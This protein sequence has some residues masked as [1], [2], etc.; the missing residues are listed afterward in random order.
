VGGAG[1][2]AR[3]CGSFAATSSTMLGKP[4]SVHSPWNRRLL[5]AFS[6][7]IKVMT[8]TLPNP[9]AKPNFFSAADFI[10]SKTILRKEK[11]LAS[12]PP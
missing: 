8:K 6:L 12:K 10:S 4:P 5:S 7:P 11:C 3:E 1:F 9:T 2:D